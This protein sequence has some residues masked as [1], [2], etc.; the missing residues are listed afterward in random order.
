[1]LARILTAACLLAAPAAAQIE[2]VARAELLPGWREGGQHVAA[3]RITLAPGWKTYWR[4]PGDAGIP[5]E[6]DWSGSEN[7]AGVGVECPVP[8]VFDQGGMQSIGYE[9][10]VTFPLLVTTRDAGGGIALRGRVSI[11]VCEDICVPV[12]F[13]V[14]GSLPRVGSH[15]A[16]ISQARAD[17]ARKGAPMTCRISPI[18]DGLRLEVEMD[19]PRMAGAMVTVIETADPSVWVSR[20][21]ISVEGQKLRASSDL[22]PPDAV[23][24]ALE[25]DGLRVTHLADGQAFETIGCN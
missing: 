3:L 21:E 14:E 13:T 1:M 18:A 6:F 23:P 8:G 24:F 11:G 9:K 7:V 2:D 19:R 16:G 17:S 25:R 15:D 12:S 4:A 20:P 22:V 5:P 10:S